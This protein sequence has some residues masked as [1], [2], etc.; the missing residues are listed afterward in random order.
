MNKGKFEL[1]QMFS[2]SKNYNNGPW[3][4]EEHA[5]FI[6]CIKAHGV[7]WTMP[8]KSIPTRTRTQIKSHLRRYFSQIKKHFDLEDP[9]E[10]IKNNNCDNLRFYKNA[11]LR[12][13]SKE[14]RSSSSAIDNGGRNSR[15]RINSIPDSK[16]GGD[17]ISNSAS[18]FQGKNL[19]KKRDLKYSEKSF[20]SS[21][22]PL[23]EKDQ[24]Y[25]K[26]FAIERIKMPKIGSK[27]K[28][29]NTQRHNQE[30]FREFPRQNISSYFIPNITEKQDTDKICI[31]ESNIGI[32]I[33]RANIDSKIP[34][35]IA[36]TKDGHIMIDPQQSIKVEIVP[37]VN[38]GTCDLLPEKYCHSQ[39]N[40]S[41][42]GFTQ[43]LTENTQNI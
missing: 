13:K 15:N 24:T 8:K 12:E 1:K 36:K 10:Y 20:K 28:N 37:T 6:Q 4:N 3:T 17:T 21:K 26:V 27:E 33:S 18:K 29:C 5:Q 38:S 30:F 11:V 35:K 43:P 32:S 42:I 7:E 14:S 19:F 40:T 2:W 39:N 25:K 16:I 34:C 31:K 9:M 22:Y 23:M 41:A